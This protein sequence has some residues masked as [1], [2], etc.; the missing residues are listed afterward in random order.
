MTYDLGLGLSILKTSQRPISDTGN[1]CRFS[2]VFKA[3]TDRGE[4]RG[5]HLHIVVGMI[6]VR[7]GGARLE[8][9]AGSDADVRA[10]T[11]ASRRRLHRGI[12]LSNRQSR[13]S[14]CTLLLIWHAN[15]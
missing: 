2:T 12:H 8:R 11:V 3:V 7:G 13:P 9:P 6:L 14:T 5:T 1:L 10:L 4:P 15:R